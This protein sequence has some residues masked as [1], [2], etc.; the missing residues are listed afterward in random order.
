MEK[1]AIIQNVKS[2]NNIEYLGNPDKL[3]IITGTIKIS[4][5][6]KK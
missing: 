2:Q 3:R 6:I 4:E 1:K 5:M